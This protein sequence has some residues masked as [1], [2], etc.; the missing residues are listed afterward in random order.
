VSDLDLKNTDDKIQTD[1]KKRGKGSRT[2]NSAK[3]TFTIDAILEMIK[4]HVTSGSDSTAMLPKIDGQEVVPL[5]DVKNA[6]LLCCSNSV[7]EDGSITIIASK[8]IA[9]HIGDQKQNAKVLEK[10]GSRKVRT[11]DIINTSMKK[12]KHDDKMS[13]RGSNGSK[14]LDKE[15]ESGTNNG[16]SVKEW[17][18][19]KTVEKVRPK[20]REQGRC[21][22]KN[23]A[24][25]PTLART[26]PEKLERIEN[27]TERLS[28]STNRTRLFEVFDD[29]DPLAYGI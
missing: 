1:K 3:S 21:A 26:S 2:K 16:G 24:K 7:N 14:W 13:E 9:D 29:V 27:K 20:D 12:R 25:P 10:K 8:I 28:D 15:R 23:N 6:I 5:A 18:G 22:I 19:N 11:N 17:N 4:D